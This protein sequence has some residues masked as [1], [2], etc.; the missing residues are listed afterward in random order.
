MSLR[1]DTAD[2]SS[3]PS[4]PSP[5]IRTIASEQPDSRPRPSKSFTNFLAQRTLRLKS[6]ARRGEGIS[7]PREDWGSRQ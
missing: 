1:N 4:L 3:A 5:R 7:G 2:T 6:T